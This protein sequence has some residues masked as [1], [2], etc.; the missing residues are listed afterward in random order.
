MTESL[1]S[2]LND[3]TFVPAEPSEEERPPVN[4][5][6]IDHLRRTFPVALPDTTNGNPASVFGEVMRRQGQQEVID[7]LADI[8]KHQNGDP[9]ELSGPQAENQSAR[10]RAP[11]TRSRS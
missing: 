7:Y 1:P 4:A 2:V 9:H 6:L 5:S 3:D 10:S 11:G 8:L